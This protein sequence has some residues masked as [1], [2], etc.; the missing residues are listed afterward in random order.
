M[1]LAELETLV[2]AMNSRVIQLVKIEK[3]KQ[4]RIQ[5]L[6][7]HR[8]VFIIAILLILSGCFGCVAKHSQYSY[9]GV[10]VLVVYNQTNKNNIY[11]NTSI[12]ITIN[13]LIQQNMSSFTNGYYI[14]DFSKCNKSY[15]IYGT[16]NFL[17]PPV[18]LDGRLQRDKP[19]VITIDSNISKAKVK[20]DKIYE[21]EKLKLEEQI[22]LISSVLLN[23]YNITITDLEYRRIDRIISP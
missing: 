23:Q 11:N 1:E 13:T 14:V 17:H 20:V 15:E 4:Q 3:Y 21:S 5:F 6:G 7:W 19:I 22:Y 8:S 2:V 10:G 12:A 18:F 9:E 16:I